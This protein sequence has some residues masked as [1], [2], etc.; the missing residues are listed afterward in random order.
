[1]WF[2]RF[3]GE[4]S[5]EIFDIGTLEDDA[6]TGAMQI[7]LVEFDGVKGKEL[8]PSDREIKRV[9]GAY[10]R[11]IV[12]KSEYA[13]LALDLTNHPNL[14]EYDGTTLTIYN[15]DKEKYGER[16]SIHFQYRVLFDYT[17]PSEESEEL[18]KY[19]ELFSY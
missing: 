14:V 17:L 7:Q 19:R 2:N 8:S 11:G 15:S 16:G 3:N 6:N 10:R 13:E 12:V 1:M 5:L 4:K 18:K 9:M